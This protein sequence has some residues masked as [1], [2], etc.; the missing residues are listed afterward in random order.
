M[1]LNVCSL[2]SISFIV[3]FLDGPQ[4]PV[5]CDFQIKLISNKILIETYI[6]IFNKEFSHFIYQFVL[7]IYFN[8][9][10]IW[11]NILININEEKRN[12]DFLRWLKS[13][14]TKNLAAYFVELFFMFIKIIFIFSTGEREGERAG[15]QSISIYNPELLHSLHSYVYL[16]IDGNIVWSIDFSA[17]RLIFP[18]IV[19]GRAVSSTQ[20]IQYI[21]EIKNV[22]LEYDTAANIRKSIS[23]SPIVNNS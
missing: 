12:R 15:I 3:I 17:K 21:T 9:T 19:N 6:L 22:W 1:A 18:D 10:K 4:G 14:S 8:V 2:R 11:L 16:F 5:Q 7:R 13:V 23:S 20:N